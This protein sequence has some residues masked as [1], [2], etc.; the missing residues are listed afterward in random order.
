[1]RHTAPW[2][3][4]YRFI[5]KERKLNHRGTEVCTEDHSTTSQCLGVSVVKL[6]FFCQTTDSR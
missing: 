4:A 1:M 3:A 5:L 2:V 6:S